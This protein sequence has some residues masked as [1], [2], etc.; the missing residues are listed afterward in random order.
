MLKHHKDLT[1]FP[2]LAQSDLKRALACPE[3]QRCHFEGKTTV[4]QKSEVVEYKPEEGQVNCLIS[5]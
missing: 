5:L 3:M 4:E 1:H 2:M